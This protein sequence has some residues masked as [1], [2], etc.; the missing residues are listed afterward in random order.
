MDSLKFKATFRG[1]FFCIKCYPLITSI[2]VVLCKELKRQES[3]TKKTRMKWNEY[4]EL[5]DSIIEGKIKDAPYNNDSF[6][7]YVKLNRSRQNRWLKNGELNEYLV[8]HVESLKSPQKWIVITEP[9]CGD[10][11]HILPFLYQLS[12]KNPAIEFKIELRDNGKNLIDQYLTDGGKSIP[13]LVVKNE[14]NSDIFVWGPRPKEAQAIHL[15]N[16]KDTT[17]T[18]EEKKL[19]LQAWYNKNRGKDLQKELLERFKSI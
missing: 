18:I 15:N 3:N 7:E 4:L 1:R 12:E 6:I 19:E 9:W 14:D 8:Q 16:K 11:S 2:N 17:K 10:A 13:I 5:F